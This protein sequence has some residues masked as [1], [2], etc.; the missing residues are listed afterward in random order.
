MFL[1]QERQQKGHHNKTV[2]LNTFIS[3]STQHTSNIIYETLRMRT[4]AQVLIEF[5]SYKRLEMESNAEHTD[6]VVRG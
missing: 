2:S 4:K 3:Y 6:E 1:L 5:F